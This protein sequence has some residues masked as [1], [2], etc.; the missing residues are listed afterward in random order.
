[1]AALRGGVTK[2]FIPEENQRDLEEIDQ[3][4]RGRLTFVP[5][6]QADEVISGALASEPNRALAAGPGVLPEFCQP[7]AGTGAALRQ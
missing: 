7:K 4:V 1:M 5:V 3:T 6:S 2:V